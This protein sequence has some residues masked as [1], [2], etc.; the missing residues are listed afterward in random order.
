MLKGFK[1][2]IL[3]GNVVDLAVAVVIA[4]RRDAFVRVGFVL[5]A[6]AMVAVALSRNWKLSWW[7]WH[8][9]MLLAF[10][11]SVIVQFN[12]PDPLLWAAIYAA[13]AAYD[14]PIALGVM[15]LAGFLPQEAAVA[16]LV[17]T[18]DPWPAFDVGATVDLLPPPVGHR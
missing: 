14:L 7:E 3:R 12:D 17:A 13:A 16:V 9:L 18:G 4:R 10:V 6:E 15:V 5:L 11:F 8:V 1:E 2:F